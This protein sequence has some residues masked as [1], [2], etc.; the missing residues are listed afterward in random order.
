MR[1]SSAIAASFGILL[2]S[3]L[4]GHAARHHVLH[5]FRLRHNR[6]TALSTAARIPSSARMSISYAVN[7]IGYG[8]VG[9]PLNSS[10]ASVSLLHNASGTAQDGS[11]HYYVTT[12]QYGN[13]TITGDYS[14]PSPY[15]HPYFYASGGDPGLGSGTNSAIALTAPAEACNSSASTDVNEV[16]TVV[17]AY[18]FAGFASDPTHVSSFQHNVGRHRRRQ[19]GQ[20]HQQS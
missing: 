16:S 12:D 6:S 8:G 14:C 20:Q 2:L 7:T 5:W 1:T 13:F 15:A 10:N 18:A 4:R 3:G 19:R 17:T 9:T 11:G